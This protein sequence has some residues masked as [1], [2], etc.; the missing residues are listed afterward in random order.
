MYRIEVEKRETENVVYDIQRE[1][2]VR[3]RFTPRTPS[4]PERTFMEP[5]LMGA[6]AKAEK[7][8]K[9]RMLIQE[10]DIIRNLL[11]MANLLF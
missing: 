1:G 7:A 3:L 6:C 4:G 5:I 10:S 8:I 2:I 11:F 9:V